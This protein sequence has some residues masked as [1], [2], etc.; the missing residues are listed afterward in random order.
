MSGV[1]RPLLFKTPEE[2]QEKI[3]SYFKECKSNKGEIVTKDGNII[4]VNQP[5]NPTIAGLAYALG[6]DR[7]TVYNY[8]SKD[9]FFDTIK[10]ARDY[11]ISQIENKLMNSSG[12]VTGPIF[13][14]KNYGYTDNRHVT[15]ESTVKIVEIPSDLLDDDE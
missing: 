7:Q 5:L 6:V 3:D 11:I 12:N 15:Q 1:G 8:E 14:A 9:Q 2:L 10:T 4:K 13:L